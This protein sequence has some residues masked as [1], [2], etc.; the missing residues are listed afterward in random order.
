MLQ[1]VK[2]WEEEILPNWQAKCVHNAYHYL[3]WLHGINKIL[4]RR[5]EK[6]TKDL[7]MKGL[8]PRCRGKVW[9]LAIGNSLNIPKGKSIN[10][11]TWLLLHY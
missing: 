2:T 11:N 5:Q 8:P 1:D 7:W 9:T 10:A 3:V 6:K 4:I